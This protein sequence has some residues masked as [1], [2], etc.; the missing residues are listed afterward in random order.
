LV[1]YLPSCHLLSAE[2]RGTKTTFSLKKPEF[3]LQ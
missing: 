1:H 2:F 3:N